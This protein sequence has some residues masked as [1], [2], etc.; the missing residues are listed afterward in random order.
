MRT[1][2]MAQRLY[3]EMGPAFLGLDDT[4][5]GAVQGAAW[6][7]LNDKAASAHAA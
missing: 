2:V 5:S 4:R 3:H 6:T 7:A 1:G